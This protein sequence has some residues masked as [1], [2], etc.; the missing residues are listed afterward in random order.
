MDKAT[1]QE[2]R[3]YWFAYGSTIRELA[4]T[5]HQQAIIDTVISQDE[6]DSSFIAK[7]IGTT[8][9]SASNQLKNLYRRGYLSRRE[10]IDESGGNKF[11]YWSNV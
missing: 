3:E 4:L 2:I 1:I 8:V 9:Q 10:I 5:S 6:V 7:D 11:I